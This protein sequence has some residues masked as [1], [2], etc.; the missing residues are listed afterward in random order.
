MAKHRPA[1]IRKS[2]LEQIFRSSRSP[3]P[4]VAAQYGVTRQAV[5]RHLRALMDESLVEAKGRGAHCQYSLRAQQKAGKSFPLL[6]GL[7]EDRVWGDVAVPLVQDLAVR[8]RDI[9]L[10]GFTEMVNNAID[11][12]Q[13]TSLDVYVERTAI[14]VTLIVLDDGVGIFHKI[15]AALSLPDPRQSILELSKGKLTTDPQH[16][17]G[18]GIFF[19]SR[20]FDKF[21]I[22]SRGLY[23]LRDHLSGDWLVED[24]KSNKNGTCV[25]MELLIPT[26]RAL[27]D[28]FRAHSS[29]P[30]EYRFSKTHVPLRLAEYG[31]DN[32]VSR[33]QAKRVLARVDRFE[34]VILD[35]SGIRAVGQAFADEIFRVFATAHPGVRL[36]PV[37]ANEQ[38][39]GMIARATDAAGRG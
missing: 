15:A 32:L 3:V 16:H 26:G 9:C 35:F 5:Q 14:A 10:Y 17:T 23:F 21:S 29:G 36:V 25:I 12:A 6:G 31:E 19:T 34:E 13:G 11:H 37:S 4:H 7:A 38:I 8:D 22:R 20:V 18:E 28:V 1:E 39:T 2:L 24:D 33:S 27:E 30:E